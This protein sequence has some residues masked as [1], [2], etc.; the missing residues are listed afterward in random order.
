MFLIYPRYID[1]KSRV[2]LVRNRMVGGKKSVKHSEDS[3]L[4]GNA[5]IFKHVTNLYKLLSDTV[6]YNSGNIKRTCYCL[7]LRSQR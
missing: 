4:L 5:V 2:H 3:T 7:N 1:K 6:S